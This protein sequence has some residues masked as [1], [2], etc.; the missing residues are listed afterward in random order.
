MP[1]TTPNHELYQPDAGQDNVADEL[2]ANMDT[3][4]AIASRISSDGTVMSPDEV[5]IAD[6]L[7]A[8][9]DVSGNVMPSGQVTFSG[10][11]VGRP[12]GDTNHGNPELIH[13]KHFDDGEYRILVN[14]T[15]DNHEL[16]RTAD[17]EN[18]TQI[19]ADILTATGLQFCDSVVLAD[20]TFVVYLTDD[21]NMVVYSGS[22]L[23]NLSSVGT[24]VPEPDGGSYL[25]HVESGTD[26][27]HLYTEDVDTPSGSVSSEKIS[28][29]TTPANDLTNATQQT[30]AIDTTDR[31]WKTGDPDIIKL[32]EWYYMFFDNTIGHPDYNIALAS[33]RDL[34]NWTII[35]SNITPQAAGGDLT[36]VKRGG[37]L[38]AM[39]EYDLN[40]AAGTIVGHWR[41]WPTP[42]T[43][44]DTSGRI[45]GGAG[46]P[47][48]WDNLD[49]RQV[50][51][52]RQNRSA[53]NTYHDLLSD[54]SVADPEKTQHRIMDANTQ[55]MAIGT[56]LGTPTWTG[57]NGR[58]M[59][60]GIPSTGSNEVTIQTTGKTGFDRQGSNVFNLHDDQGMDMGAQDLSLTTFGAT[61]DGRIYRH[62][63]ASSI[64]ADGATTSSAG[65][66]LWDNS[67]AEFKAIVQF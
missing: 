34:Y 39:T 4:D 2:N 55:I 1:N 42:Q 26:I 61:E 22:D 24:A 8:Q 20:G 17:F 19:S 66:Y 58:D 30:D 48:I 9:G 37:H 14:Q 32:G 21:T 7:D 44:T 38:E 35:K 46:S 5:S 47:T 40:D 51:D 36:V 6:L 15:Q 49:D 27:V 62:N 50:A 57:Y 59:N 65:Y 11:R 67:A 41:L 23:Q 31:D 16:W 56:Y 28:H 12:F 13:A 64:T 54:P 29:W 18:Y 25:E 60:I 3:L 53:G 33:S 63:G 10:E 43:V 52:Y 45:Y